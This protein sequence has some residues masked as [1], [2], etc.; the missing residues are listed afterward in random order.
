MRILNGKSLT[1]HGNRAGR[2]KALEIL[3]AGL[4]AAD[5]YV[6]AKELV[7][8]E[9][10]KIWIGNPDFEPAGSPKTGV[11]CWKLGSEIERIFV[12]GAGKGVQRAALGLEEV[13]GDALTGGHV[14]AKKGDGVLLKRIRVT[15]GGHPVPDED[16]VEGC[17][18]MESEIK[19]L[20]LTPRDLVFTIV[21]NGV[22]SLL[23]LPP[24]GVS[25]QD[26]ASIT[27]VLQ[28]E[29]GLVTTK[30]NMVRNQI[31]RLK[32]GRITRLL[33]PARMIHLVLIDSNEKNSFGDSGYKGL[34]R[35]NSWLHTLPD[36]SNVEAAIACLH[37]CDAWEQMP[38]AV[39]RYFEEAAVQ[40]PGLSAEEFEQMD[41]RIYGIMPAKGNYL[42]AA[43]DKAAS[44]G[45]QPVLLSRRTFT[46]ARETGAFVAQIGKTIEG[47]HSPFTPPCAV[48]L[49]GELLVKVEKELGIG[50]RNQ[51]F[52]LAAASVIRGSKSI[53]I[54]TADTDGTDGPGGLFDQG[55]WERGCRVL[56]GGLVDGE[57]FQEAQERGVDLLAA[58]KQ[59]NTSEALWKLDSGIWATQNVSVCD[60]IVML[61]GA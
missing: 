9:A 41:C 7:R 1:S 14:I 13:L 42:S 52:A 56:T 31:D 34:T 39:Q 40:N 25:I 16:C 50:G 49:T 33:A 55:A 35:T 8:L 58:L 10:G 15:E 6:R 24:D 43:M 61:V 53:V 37:E 32:G 45:F 29:K 51:E 21:G 46:E 44:F 59:H 48:F 60:L 30:L 5:P 4:T 23:T 20:H 22:S 26:V 38:A 17:R 12:F 3:E 36:V 57:T 54:A 11:D 18:Q 27:Q 2:K 47:E 19:A 28:I